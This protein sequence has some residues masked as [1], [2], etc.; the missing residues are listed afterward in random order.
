[1]LF[2]IIEM[3]QIFNSAT[4]GAVQ[5]QKKAFFLAEFVPKIYVTIFFVPNIFVPNSFVPI[6]LCRICADFSSEF[7]CAE[8]FVPNI[9]CRMFC[10]IF[11]TSWG[12]SCMF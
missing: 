6:F 7:F 1:M 2:L 8:F 10:D 5:S 4:L 12:E 11:V 3:S 9:L